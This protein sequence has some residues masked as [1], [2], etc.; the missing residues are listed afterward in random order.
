MEPSDVIVGLHRT[1]Q[2]SPVNTAALV[3]G[4]VNAWRA[5]RDK[6]TTTYVC[7][8]CKTQLVDLRCVDCA[9]QYRL[10]HGF[11]VLLPND[12]RYHAA[13]EIA[14]VYDSI[15]AWH[16]S[17][18]ERQGQSREFVAYFAGLLSRFRA[19]RVLEVGCGEG[20]LLAALPAGERYGTELSIR[21]LERAHASTSAGLCVALGE[22]LPY[23]DG[24]FDVVTSIGV[25]EHFLDDRAACAEIFRVLRDGGRYVVLVHLHLTAWQNLRQ[26]ISEYV[27]PR[28]RPLR[29]A[30]W[31]FEKLYRP[32]QQ[33]IQNRYTMEEARSRLERSGFTVTDVVH[34]GNTPGAPLTGPHV[35]IYVCQKPPAAPAIDS[36]QS[37]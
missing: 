17:V 25:M 3:C 15:Y 31:L 20:V 11:P 8:D 4:P 30:R 33:P 13:R 26:Q 34:K 7:P 19:R 35:V 5:R 18:W 29:A 32:V 23:G 6:S 28:P 36:T 16:P 12:P 10:S 22:R 37:A 2:S 1:G 21:A 14:A 24:F 27:F 9:H